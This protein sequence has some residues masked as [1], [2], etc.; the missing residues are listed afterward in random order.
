MNQFLPVGGFRWCNKTIGEVLATLDNA[1]YGYTVETDIEYPEHL[2]DTHSD[3]PLALEAI[4]L[5]EPWISDYQYS[6]VNELGGK[7]IECVKLV[8]NQCK[9]ERYVLNYR[10]LKLY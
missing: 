6:S 5:S 1:E 3:Y 2:Y 9:K 4:I 8:L 7:F 10:N